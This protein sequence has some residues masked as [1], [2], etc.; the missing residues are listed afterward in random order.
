MSPVLPPPAAGG[1]GAAGVQL[2]TFRVAGEDFAIDIMRVREIIQPVEL[3]PVPEAPAH[4]AGV[5][6]FRGEVVPVVDLRRRLGL[7]A[8]PPSRRARFV[9]V[10]VAG[11]L[12]GLMVDEVGEVLRLTRG[13]LRPAP[14]ALDGTGT[15]LFLGVCDGAHRAARGERQ[16]G[17]GRLH[18][19][20][21]VK[22]LL[23]RESVGGI[24]AARA[25]VAGARDP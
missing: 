22:A 13:D 5:L 8:G 12:L 9:V 1:A 16:G 23:D 25:L 4:V 19:L 21:N 2:C 7:P 15:R 20:L 14:A 6:R 24:E 10:K 3:T 17:A 11:G 18:L